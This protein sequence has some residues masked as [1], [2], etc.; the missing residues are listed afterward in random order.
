[1]KAGA[2]L[3]R[4]R[5]LEPRRLFHVKH[6]VRSVIPEFRASEISGTQEYRNARVQF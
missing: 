5:P 2:T 3:A 1:M 4:F 6:R